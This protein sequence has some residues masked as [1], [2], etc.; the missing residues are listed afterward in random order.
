M[1]QEKLSESNPSRIPSNK[2]VD[3]NT[4]VGEAATKKPAPEEKTV[5]LGQLFKYAK[6]KDKCLILIATILA[7]LHGL[8]IPLFSVVFGRVTNDFTPD[9]SPQERRD[10]AIRT[11]IL[12]WIFGFIIFLSA[13]GGITLWRYI[14]TRM[15]V[16]LKEM[17]YKKVLEQEM[18]W[19]D[20]QNPESL[21]TKYTEEFA[22]F[23]K[24]S[25]SSIHILCFSI[26]LSFS[27]LAIG[28]IYGWLYSLCLLVTMPILFIGGSGFMSFEQEKAQKAKEN[29]ADAGAVSEQALGA[30]KT[31]KSL[32]GEEHEVK[33][34][35][36]TL[37]SAKIASERLGGMGAFFFGVMN[38]SFIITY[39]AGYFIGSLFLRWGVHNHNTGDK[40]SAGDVV[41]IFFGVTT[42]IFG[43]NQMGPALQHIAAAKQAAYDVYKL[44]ER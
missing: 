25:G 37:L 35:W 40:Y 42:G 21:T 2:V 15:M 17:Y 24:G 29:Y 18:G 39:A 12:A 27:G 26:C 34:Y 3:I 44:V 13:G 8:M 20:L 19:F 5:T 38:F 36:K 31:V 6:P 32:N 43:M 1:E 16:N 14:G 28:F 7:C 33:N 11:S 22:A 30:I 10:K 4:K 23:G 41:S 9:K